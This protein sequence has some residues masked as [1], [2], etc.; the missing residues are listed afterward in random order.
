MLILT[1]KPNESIIIN[2][3]IKIT[4]LGMHASSQIRIGINAPEE[5]KIY[6]EEIYKKIQQEKQNALIEFANEE[7]VSVA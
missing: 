3:H 5:I 7:E 2:D 6:R 4:V 1:R